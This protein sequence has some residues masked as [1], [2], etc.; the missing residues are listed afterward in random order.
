MPAMATLKQKR[1]AEQDARAMLEDHGLPQPD[2]VE[3]GD[4]CVR[5]LW[6]EEQVALVVDIDEPPEGYVF[7]EPPTGYVSAEDLP[8]T[9][10]ES[11]PGVQDRSNR[12][13]AV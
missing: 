2:E 5:L 12:K 8:D 3:Y 7:D 6:R 9:E 13:P 10:F 1:A 4:A 11:I